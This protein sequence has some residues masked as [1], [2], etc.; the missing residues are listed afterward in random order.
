MIISKIQNRIV[1]LIK[2]DDEEQV[3]ERKEYCRIVDIGRKK[4]I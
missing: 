2:Q 1:E 4:E 3:D